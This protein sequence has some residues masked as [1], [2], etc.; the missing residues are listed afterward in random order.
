MRMMI[1]WARKGSRRW[2]EWVANYCHLHHIYLQDVSESGM[3][4]MIYQRHLWALK[5]A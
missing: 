5:Y 3:R 1:M 2:M 4:E